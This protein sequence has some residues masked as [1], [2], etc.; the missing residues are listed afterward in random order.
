MTGKQPGHR[1]TTSLYCVRVCERT[2]TR[3]R[4]THNP[5]KWHA[6]PDTYPDTLPDLVRH[7]NPDTPC[8][9]CGSGITHPLC[10]AAWGDVIR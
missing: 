3:T 8:P 6:N 2:P 10:P 4:P 9:L 1:E 5:D 7:A